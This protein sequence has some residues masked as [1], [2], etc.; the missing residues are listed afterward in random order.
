V[1]YWYKEDDT[2]K[3]LL[4]SILRI[5]SHAAALDPDKTRELYPE[6][7]S[8]YLDSVTGGDAVVVIGYD[9]YSSGSQDI[10]E[11]LAVE[12]VNMSIIDDLRPRGA[13]TIPEG[14]FRFI[15][16]P[17]VSDYVCFDNISQTIAQQLSQ[18]GDKNKIVLC[19]SY[20]GYTIS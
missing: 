6:L 16:Y 12:G 20:L 5:A 8:T 14:A 11:R 17:S 3:R 10:R 2:V 9:W 18:I 7:Y 1:D 19:L 4:N 13:N 15:I